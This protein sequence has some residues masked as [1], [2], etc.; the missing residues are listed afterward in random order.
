[1][2]HF[3]MAAVL[4]L[5]GSG[6][7][8]QIQQGTVVLSGSVSMNRT[9]FTTEANQS[10]QINKTTSLGFNP[11][12]GYLI[13]DN[14]A[15]G[16]ALLLTYNSYAQQSSRTRVYSVGLSPYLRK[17]WP[18][19]EQLYLTG[20]ASVFGSVGYSKLTSENLNDTGNLGNS[21]SFGANLA[22]GLTFFV[23]ERLSLNSSLSLL[24]FSST[25]S[26]TDNE[27]ESSRYMSNYFTFSPLPSSI[28]FGLS[29][30]FNQK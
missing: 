6:A 16:A 15:A 1:M 5:A 21:Y 12:M 24:S 14:L 20:T 3:F 28:A 4:A 17:Y 23:T 30:Y 9:G 22:P 8:A 18:V 13:K 25:A 29:Y 2:K 19:A 7:F 10:E 26:K 27:P 11:A